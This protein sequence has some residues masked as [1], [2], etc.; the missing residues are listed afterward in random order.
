MRAD[1]RPGAG[2]RT[3]AAKPDSGLAL[4]PGATGP[5]LREWLDDASLVPAPVAVFDTRMHAPLGLSGSAGRRIARQLKRGGYDVVDRPRGFFVTKQNRLIDGELP[6]A[7]EWGAQL[8][9]RA[10]VRAA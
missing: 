8:A 7:R 10:S 3:P 5:G 1:P 4:E 6:R 9:R 2:P